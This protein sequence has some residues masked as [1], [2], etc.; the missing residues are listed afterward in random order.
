[1]FPAKRYDAI[2]YRKKLSK[3]EKANGPKED[4]ANI[5]K[6]LRHFLSKNIPAQLWPTG[7]LQTP[8][9]Y[10]FSKI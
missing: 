10:K 4:G 3:A 8:T 7:D 5:F 9:Y 2:F 6:G 1:M